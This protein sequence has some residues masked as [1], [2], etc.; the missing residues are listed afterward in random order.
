MQ[1]SR[2]LH[3][4]RRKN[5]ITLLK[6][7][8]RR[9]EFGASSRSGLPALP[10]GRAEAVLK[11]PAL[12]YGEVRHRKAQLRSRTA[13]PVAAREEARRL[14]PAMA[15]KAEGQAHLRIARTAIPQLRGKVR[16]R[17]GTHGRK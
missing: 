12:F 16:A 14:R 9:N 13:R 11:R 3:G 15:R 10:Q 5:G 1:W 2:V 8:R 7:E 17:P 4:A 6:K